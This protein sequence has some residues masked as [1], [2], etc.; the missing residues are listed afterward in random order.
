MARKPRR[1]AY[2]DDTHKRPSM[3][4]KKNGDRVTRSPFCDSRIAAKIIFNQRRRSA[5]LG[6]F[7]GEPEAVRAADES[8]DSDLTTP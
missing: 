2:Q 3:A 6:T 8:S 7:P 5:P 1:G 4:V